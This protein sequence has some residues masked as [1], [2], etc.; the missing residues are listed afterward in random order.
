MSG[1]E[2]P[3]RTRATENIGPIA[4]ACATAWIVE[5]FRLP[6]C[7][8]GSVWLIAVPE[9]RRRT[10]WGLCA[11]RPAVDRRVVDR[12][13][14]LGRPAGEPLRLGGRLDRARRIG[15]CSEGP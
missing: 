11:L 5:R 6:S 1:R 9:D 12:R 13:G 7:G 10:G 15:V 2:T 8:A 4:S 14:V 3:P